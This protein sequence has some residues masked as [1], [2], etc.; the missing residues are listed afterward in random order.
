[1]NL[2]RRQ[3][4]AGAIGAAGAGLCGLRRGAAK[5]SARDPKNLI[6]V[7][8]Q[9]G[10]DLTYTFDP[11]PGLTTVDAPEGA[12]AEVS[13][14]PIFVHASRPKTRQ[15]FEEHGSVATIVNGV[16]V[17]SINHPDCAKRMLTG[18][19]SETNP[20]LGA[21]TA[22]ELG[23]D[24]PAPYLALGP[25]AFP[26]PLGSIAVRT[27]TV[28]Q[29]QGLLDPARAFPPAD[30]S[31][32]RFVPSEQEAALI[33]AHV[34]AGAARIRATR[35]QS[36]YNARRLDDFLASLDRGE[37]L[38][39]FNGAFPSDFSFALDLTVQTGIA[40]RA[41][42]EGLSHAVQCEASFFGFDTHASNELQ[43][44]LSEALFEALGGLMV[45][46]QATPGKQSGHTLLDETVVLVASEMGRTPK[47][48]DAGGKDHWP[49]T[50][51]LVLGGGLRGGRVLGGTGDGLEALPVDLATG[52]VVQQGTRLSYSNFA[53]GLLGAVGVDASSHLPNTE[54]FHAL[55]A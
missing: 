36:G 16:Q 13:G 49:V 14:L 31:Y 55:V 6:V 18:T 35:G 28:S 8:V 37:R 26:G 42:E 17:Q 43:G 40:V 44:P 12:I 33:E 10:W 21:I 15:F 34:Q 1:M 7:F 27:G 50:S 9:G 46:L 45:E 38:K 25:T 52:E 41:I 51:A 23:R 47:L 5:G 24:L 48:N 32:Q 39:R 54:P 4:L 20:D 2:S 19:A 29:I 22:Y 53:A 3:W 11:K 30:P